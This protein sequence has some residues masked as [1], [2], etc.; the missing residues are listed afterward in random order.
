MLTKTQYSVWT[1]GS[2]EDYKAVTSVTGEPVINSMKV[3]AEEV[4]L[5]V[6][7]FLPPGS[8]SA[9]QL[10]QIQKEKRDL[11]QEYLENWNNTVRETGTGRPVDAIIAP[12][13]PFSAVPHGMN[14]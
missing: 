7:E 9:Y 6:N 13:S 8:V 11:R 10:W 3:T 12:V 1:A 4:D 5:D 2:A 14:A